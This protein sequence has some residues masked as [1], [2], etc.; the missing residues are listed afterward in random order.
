MNRSSGR[1]TGRPAV[2]AAATLTNVMA[3]PRSAVLLALALTGIV[4]L[5]SAPPVWPTPGTRAECEAAGGTWA[6]YGIRQQE[7]CNLPSPDAG[8]ACSDAKDCASACV[9][10]DSA[11]V[12]AALTGTC[13]ARMLLLGQCLK[14]VR[15]G[16]V[17]PPLCAD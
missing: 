8:K 9:A 7:M 2:S 6:R 17:T 11:P 3:R 1:R 10:P 5:W 12:G 16:V 4:C 14:Q 15:D 13:Y